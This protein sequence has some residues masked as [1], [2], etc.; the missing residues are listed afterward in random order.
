MT[1]PL[2]Q[3]GEPFGTTLD[4]Q[5]GFGRF[6]ANVAEL[7]YY[8]QEKG[9]ICGKPIKQRNHALLPF[10]KNFREPP[11]QKENYEA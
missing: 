6:L 1:A 3:Q 10:R 9:T 4:R 11:C 7:C 2:D 8:Y 5:G